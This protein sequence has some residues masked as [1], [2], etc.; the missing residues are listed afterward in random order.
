MSSKISI[1]GIGWLG[2][3]LALHLI[4]KG[5][6]IKGS[7]TSLMKLKKLKQKG[8][9]PYHII[10]KENKV[11][12]EIDE[13][14][15]ESE[16]LIINIPPGLRSN[17]DIDFVAKI[18][19]LLKPLQKSSVKK[20]LFISSTSVFEDQ[21]D[22]PV[23]NNKNI[24]HASKNA[25]KQLIA[26][27]E[28]LRQNNKFATTIIRF[29]G[30]FGPDRHPATMLSGRSNLKNPEAPINL[31]HQQDCIEIIDTIL[32]QQYWKQTLNAAYP[33]HLQKEVYYTT[34]CKQMDLPIPQYDKETASKGKTIDADKVVKEL[35]YEFKKDLY[36]I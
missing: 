10:L 22:F 26:T 12:G 35:N 33:D 5:Y 4:E 28:L 29:G 18:R 19:G 27:E 32:E 1:L 3:P 9:Q 30:L 11:A 25:G 20:V 34:I 24:P 21:E 17:P 13:F 8:I 16:I 14:L 7:T 36:T 31:I 2:F 23:I 6:Q 15:E